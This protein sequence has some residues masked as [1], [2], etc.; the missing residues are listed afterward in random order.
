MAS[1]VPRLDEQICE[2]A[3]LALEKQTDIRHEYMDGYVYA[4]VGGSFNHGRI[5]QNLAR[6]IGNYLEGKPCEVFAEST[7]VKMPIAYGRSNYV[8]PDVVVD[9][10]VNKAEDNTLTTP[11][12]VVEVLSKSTHYRD[13]VTKRHLYQQIESL[14]EYVLVEQDV[15]EVII[16]RRCS[17]WIS[18]EFFLGDNV[19]FESIN[20]TL[21]V[22]DI[23]DRV[24]NEEMA[25]WLAQKTP[26]VNKG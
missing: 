26:D 11:V 15:V 21:T 10:S 17:N 7:K 13:K 4:M 2:E 16:R 24:Q 20:L 18:E 8:Y 6:K 1:A 14:Q 25:D 23:Y 12:I 3:Y 9:C 22:A 19:T 5:T